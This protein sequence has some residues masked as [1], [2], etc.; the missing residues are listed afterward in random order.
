MASSSNNNPIKDLS[1][2]DFNDEDHKRMKKKQKVQENVVQDLS[3]LKN[4]GRKIY[5]DLNEYD[6]EDGVFD[7]FDGEDYFHSSDS[8]DDEDDSDYDLE[9][10]AG[11]LDVV[12]DASAAEV[13][14]RGESEG[15]KE[16][17]VGESSESVKENVIIDVKGKGKAVD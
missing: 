14:K 15:P 4:E 11:F 16:K 1:P 5:E 17:V 9:D 7:D 13:E 6:F 10:V 12:V 2:R 8:D 3:S